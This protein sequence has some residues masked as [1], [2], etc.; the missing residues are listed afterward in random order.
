M[1]KSL[2]RFEFEFLTRFENED[3]AAFS[4][5]PCIVVLSVGEPAIAVISVV[6]S[7]SSEI[8]SR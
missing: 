5:I 1:G 2:T 7:D 6:M 4:L 3:V 8:F